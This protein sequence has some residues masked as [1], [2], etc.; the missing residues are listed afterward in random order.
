MLGASRLTQGGGGVWGGHLC[1]TRLCNNTL[2]I[3]R[4]RALSWAGGYQKLQ[5]AAALCELNNVVPEGSR[6][7]DSGLW[8]LQEGYRGGGDVRGEVM[9]KQRLG[10]RSRHGREKS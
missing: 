4:C 5:T 6:D 9:F 3:S 10:G 2:T 1:L 8:N 7:A